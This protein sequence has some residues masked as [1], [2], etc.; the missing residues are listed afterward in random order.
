LSEANAS[1][2]IA[3][4]AAKHRGDWESLYTAYAEFY[5]VAQTADMRASVWTW[6]ADDAHELSGFLAI[7]A[8]GRGIGL[9]HYRP[10]TRPLAASTGGFLDD[11]FVSPEWRGK[12]VAD[13]LV[14]AVV[15]E[16][17]ARRWTVV[18]WIT[19]EDNHRGRGFYDRVAE[20]THWVT[21]QIPL[22]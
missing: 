20:R 13:A 18:R 22:V 15:A 6:L 2:T 4:I 10:F 9:A 8:N 3:P 21:Y 7:D 5:A 19:A 14:A 17:R 11:L 12:R 16:A 1:F